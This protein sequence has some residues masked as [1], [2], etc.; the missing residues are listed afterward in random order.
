MPEIPVQRTSLTTILLSDLLI[1]EFRH[2]REVFVFRLH[3]SEKRVVRR[4]MCERGKREF[5]IDENF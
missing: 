2:F 3:V 1:R 4:K 5:G